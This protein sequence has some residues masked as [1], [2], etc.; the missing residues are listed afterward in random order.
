MTDSKSWEALSQASEEDGLW[1]R[2]L[3][4][5]KREETPAGSRNKRL[6]ALSLWTCSVAQ[7]SVILLS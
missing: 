7:N 1:A 2:H 5:V 6:R 3:H 4:N